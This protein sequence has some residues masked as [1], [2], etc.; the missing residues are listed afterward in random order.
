M[1]MLLM[2]AIHIQMLPPSLGVC[3]ITYRRTR[4]RSPVWSMRL[5]VSEVSILISKELSLAD[6]AAMPDLQYS[7]THNDQMKNIR[8]HVLPMRCMLHSHTQVSHFTHI[9]LDSEIKN[10]KLNT[11]AGADLTK[12]VGPSAE[13]V[14]M[15]IAFNYR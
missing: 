12:S 2:P 13:F 5:I 6:C 14:Q 7:A 8:D 4:L 11:S 9:V 1:P 3:K 15:P 10:Y